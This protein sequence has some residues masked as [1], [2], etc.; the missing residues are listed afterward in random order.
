MDFARERQT[1]WKDF[2]E[3]NFLPR[4]KRTSQAEVQK[5][6]DANNKTKAKS[7]Q[8]KLSIQ[9]QYDALVVQTDELLST[10]Y[11]LPLGDEKNRMIKE[12]ILKWRDFVRMLLPSEIQGKTQ[13]DLSDYIDN[14]GEQMENL[15][16][17]RRELTNWRD[18]GPWYKDKQGRNII[19]EELYQEEEARSRATPESIELLDKRRAEADPQIAVIDRAWD[20]LLATK[21]KTQKHIEL[22]RQF[23][24]LSNTSFDTDGEA[25]TKRLRLECQLCF[26]KVNLSHCGG[27]KK[28]VYCSVEC[29]SQDY[30][31]HKNQCK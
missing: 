24:V 7:T 31:R 27:C 20:S 14:L 12:L 18:S 11:R 2:V 3:T 22:L 8:K 21:R 28:A 16:D 15:L 13:Q 6:L 19:Y 29:Q 23:D 26:K 17:K 4:E 25:S 1:A 10:M 5:Y 9:N 30:G